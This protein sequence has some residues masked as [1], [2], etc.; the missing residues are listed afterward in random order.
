MLEPCYSLRPQPQAAGRSCGT[1]PVAFN[2][3]GKRTGVINQ[4]RDVQSVWGLGAVGV[5]PVRATAQQRHRPLRVAPLHVGEADRQLRQTLP[6]LAVFPRRRL[7]H[8]LEHLV[9]MKGVTVVD[10]PLRLPHR[11]VRAE[12]GVLGNPVNPARTMRQRPALG[13]SG[14]GVAGPSGGVPVTAV[15]P[16]MMTDHS[17]FALGPG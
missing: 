4:A 8:P 6:Q 1:Q 15:H 3:G 10:E 12:H 17:S 14:T 9:G 13:I 5:D 11:I 16:C 2:A 7:P